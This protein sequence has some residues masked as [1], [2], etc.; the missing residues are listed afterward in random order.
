M[1]ADF[2]YGVIVTAFL[3]ALYSVGAAIYG[4]RTKSAGW[5]EFGSPRHAI[6]VAAHFPLCRLVDLFACHEL[7]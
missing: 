4:E 3:V 6:V 1:I 2:G 7:F 5:V